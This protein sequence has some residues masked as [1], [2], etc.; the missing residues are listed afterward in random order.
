[1]VPPTNLLAESAEQSSV[2]EVS[3]E[4]SG[5]Q[6]ITVDTLDAW[7]DGR[8]TAVRVLALCVG[9]GQ[10]KLKTWGKHNFDTSGFGRLAKEHH[11]GVVELL[12]E[13][14]N[15]TAAIEQGRHQQYS[16]QDIL[17]TR[18]AT[19]G[20]AKR[21]ANAGRGLE[22]LLE[23]I[24]SDLGLSYL[25]RGRFTG[26]GGRTAPFDLAIL[27]E[28]SSPVVVVAAK[29][30]DST[31]SKLT[32]AVREVEEMAQVRL[33]TQ[34]VYAAVDGIGWKG[35]QADFRRLHGLWADS[36]IDGIYSA[37]TLPD[38]KVELVKA[39]RRLGLL[40]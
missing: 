39:C 10:E 14:H 33:P 17:V 25:T 16:Y 18:A 27:D 11:R 15:L 19:T 6:E 7:I 12:E 21:A 31:G 32:D 22:D 23:E 9:M 26:I 29:G 30:F 40:G 2:R 3:A 28:N 37:S 1:M 36:K 5:L 4:L 34:F 24:A 35:R 8:A 38:F 20:T 13:E